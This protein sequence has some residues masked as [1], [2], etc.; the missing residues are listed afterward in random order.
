MHFTSQLKDKSDVIYKIIDKVKAMHKD[1][2]Y[3]NDGA[4]NR[5]Y[6]VICPMPICNET[7][8]VTVSDNGHVHGIC[9]RNGCLNWKQ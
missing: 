5:E 7:I 2:V 6:K 9:E 8:H 4:R 3:P 1:V